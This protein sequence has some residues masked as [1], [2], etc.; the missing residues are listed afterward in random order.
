[1][2][3]NNTGSSVPSSPPADQPAAPN[4]LAA[5]PSVPVGPKPD[6]SSPGATAGIPQPSAAS[7]PNPVNPN[8][9][10][11]VTPPPLPEAHH[12]GKPMLWVMILLVFA[13]FCGLLLAVWY[14]QTQVQKA[15]PG[16]GTETTKV[17]ATT[18]SKITIGTDATFQ[19]MEY[20][21]S[22]GA[23]MGYDIDL[24][25]RI[26]EALGAE[27]E[28]KNI[29]WDD[30][31]KALANKQIDMVMSSVTVTEERKQMY[32]FSES[33]LNA[34]QV[35]IVRKT[36]TT[37]TSAQDLQGKKIAVQEGTT[38]ETEALKLTTAALVIRYPDFVLATKALVDG[39]ADAIL[40]DLPGAKGIITENPTLK[41]SSDPLTNEYYGIVFRK[42][43]PNVAKIN[44]ILSS[45]KT[46]GVLTDLKQKWL[47]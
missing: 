1:M 24:G 46:Q 14:F 25:N 39:N 29:P 7:A 42:D 41:I 18:P 17:P 15:S 34:G 31:F 26:G 43:D 8:A 22:G 16:T 37:I 23:L 27:V 33:Y 9:S 3:Q 13:F 40:S 20:T 28:F 45:F 12:K 35:I 21:A 44:E 6:A 38:N 10:P 19:P 5:Q 4:P 2:D 36:D 47:D 30:L 32:D 11:Q